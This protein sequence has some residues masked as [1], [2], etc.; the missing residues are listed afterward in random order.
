MFTTMET[1]RPILDVDNL[2]EHPW[3]EIDWDGFRSYALDWTVDMYRQLQLRLF[4]RHGIQGSDDDPSD[5][6]PY[7]KYY[8]FY[9]IT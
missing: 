4:R 3:P 2:T 6:D 1:P 7:S 9:C 8:I 5:P